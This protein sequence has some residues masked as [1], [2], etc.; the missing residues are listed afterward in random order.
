IIAAPNGRSTL[1]PVA[2]PILAVAG[3]GD[4]LAGII[5]ALIAQGL[6][7]YDAARLGAWLHAQAGRQLAKRLGDRGA[8]AR[9]VADEIPSIF[10]SL[11]VD[12]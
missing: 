8:L 3:S 2:H 5:T 12:S 1:I 11:L 7:P 10:N 6:A 9:E 4:V